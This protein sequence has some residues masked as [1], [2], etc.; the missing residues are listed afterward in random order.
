MEIKEV[1]N[2]LLE[3]GKII[4][5]IFEENG[6]PYMIT[7]G[8]LLGAVRHKG[9]I[10]W[11]DD[12]DLFLF[13][14]SYDRAMLL[15][16][17]NLPKDMFLEDATTEP[18]YFH[19]WAHVKDTKTRAVC[20]QYPQDNIYAHQGISIDL[21]CAF[22]MRE[23]KVDLFRLKEQL[24]YQQR[25]QRVGLITLKEFQRVQKEIRIKIELEENGLDMENEAI[26]YGMVLNERIMYPNEIFPLKKYKFENY[27][28][29][30][31]DDS[32]ALLTRFYGD[33][34]KL[35]EEKN[36]KPHYSKVEKY[37]EMK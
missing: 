23:N 29:Y 36:R 15:L 32:D 22:E 31:P 7:F 21:Y 4:C 35:P 30:G 17:E 10:P 33:Y 12:F 37:H 26:A 3:M 6:I 18:L 11:D 1:Q 8:T 25:K 24:K 13:N 20:E 16:K 34:M 14:D 28:F 19:S 27:E 2:R 5:D 9:F